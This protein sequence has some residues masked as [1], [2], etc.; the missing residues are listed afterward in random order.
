[1]D[2][3]PAM[4]SNG[5][6][7]QVSFHCCRGLFQGCFCFFT[8]L[9]YMF[10]EFN[11]WLTLCFPSWIRSFVWVSPIVHVE[12]GKTRRW[13]D[14]IVVGEFCAWQPFSPVG[15]PVIDEQSKVLFDFLIHPFGLT[16]G[17]GMVGGWEGY[18]WFRWVYSSLSW[19]VQQIVGLDHWWFFSVG[20]VCS[21]RW[22]GAE[23]VSKG[24]TVYSV[25]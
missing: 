2:E 3:Y 5:P 12:R 25:W 4:R 23:R 24:E 22:K 14:F 11:C 20:R 19:I 9:L 16:I 13:L 1:M 17:L 10:H 21:K 8:D 6:L 18:F 7:P 15:L